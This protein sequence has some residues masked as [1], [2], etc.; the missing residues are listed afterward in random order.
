MLAPLDRPVQR[1]GRG[2]ARAGL[3]SRRTALAALGG[4]G[5]VL[6]AAC[7]GKSSTSSGAAATS[8]TA[9]SSTTSA[10]S[11][12]TSTVAST[13]STAAATRRN[14]GASTTTAPTNVTLAPEMTEG[15][16]YL[17]LDLV[18]SDVRED[19]TGATLN[20]DFIVMDVATQAPVSGAAV[21]IW[22]CDAEGI[23]SGF[24]AA[25][26]GSNNGGAWRGRAAAAPA[27]TTRRSCGAPRSAAATAG[28]RSPP[29]TPA[30]TR[31]APCTS[32]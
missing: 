17:D 29:S 4:G 1:T 19:R 7:S 25:S 23:Y 15:P 28:R 20:L 11:G 13:A 8:S 16:Y 9:G 3:I 18:R 14:G 30:G 32:M 12:S 27:P 24:V 5:L 22:H 26:T 6:L 2:L 31:D 10:S 21:D